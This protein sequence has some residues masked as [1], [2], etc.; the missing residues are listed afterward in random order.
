MD[1]AILEEYLIWR[2]WMTKGTPLSELRW[3]WTY[4]DILKANAILDYQEAY[5]LAIEGTQPE[6]GSK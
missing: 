6:V 5:D 4:P 3:Q 2:I 1:E